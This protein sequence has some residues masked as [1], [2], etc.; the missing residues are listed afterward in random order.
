MTPTIGIPPRYVRL[1]LDHA[2]DRNESF[3]QLESYQN[4]LKNEDRHPEIDNLI[5]AVGEIAFGIYADLQ[6]NPEVY[7]SGD[8]GVDFHVSIDDEEYTM[9][10]K[11]RT[12][13]LFAFWVKE[14]KIQADYYV[15]GKLEAPV[16]FD[17]NDLEDLETYGGW[18]V[19]LLGVATKE[20]LLDA[21]GIESDKGWVNR[22]ILLDDLDPVL[23]LSRSNSETGLREGSG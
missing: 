11:T 17:T 10:M 12:G 20:E 21:R 2:E 7:D 22:L 8:S 1:A 13:D 23:S 15:L 14:H 18:E 19:E 3:K 6:I 5:G 16:N 4:R 9:D